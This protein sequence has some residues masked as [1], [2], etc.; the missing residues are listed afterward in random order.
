MRDCSSGGAQTLHRAQTLA[1]LAAEAS[2]AGFWE[3]EPRTG[4][5]HWDRRMRAI[6]GYAEPCPPDAYLER[7]VHPDDR[8]RVRAGLDA[9]ATGCEPTEY[10]I[11]WPDGQVRWVRGMGA[12]VGPG[13]SEHR[14]ALITVIDITELAH[15]GSEVE[16]LDRIQMVSP[17]AAHNLNNLLGVVLPVLE[18]LAEVLPP[19]EDPGIRE[20]KVACTEARALVEDLLA[21]CRPGPSSERAPVSLRELAHETVALVRRTCARRI[22]IEVACSDPLEVTVNATA[23]RQVLLNLLL[24]ARDAV[25]ESKRPRIRVVGR[26]DPAH[27]VRLA[28]VD[29]GVGM[30][31]AVAARVFERYFTTKGSTGTGLGLASSREMVMAQGGEL[32]LRTAPGRG[33][34]FEIVLPP[35]S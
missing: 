35:R 23:M 8:V 33:A 12:F 32:Q 34:A 9:L 10:R 19:G 26:R 24:N 22:G 1:R 11:T 15:L 14:E 31:D 18:E 20:A 25:A 17:G 13:E 27:R 16:R 7:R 28:V 30:S 5:V 21:L 2:G 29:N 4:R 3:W 6:H